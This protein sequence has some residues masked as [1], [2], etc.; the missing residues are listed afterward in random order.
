[1]SN[2]IHVFRISRNYRS[3]KIFTA[4][5]RNKRLVGTSTITL[6]PDLSR[7]ERYDAIVKFLTTGFKLLSL[8]RSGLLIE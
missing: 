3:C 8:T 1:M 2:C 6:N 7:R 5:R 4:G